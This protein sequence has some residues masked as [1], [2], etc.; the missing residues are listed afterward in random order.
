MTKEV[1]V[2]GKSSTGKTLIALALAARAREAGRR[3]SYF[4]PI[5]E[6]SYPFQEAFSVDPDA[7]L[8]KEHL[9][10]PVEPEVINPI[11]RTRASYDEFLKTGREALLSRIRECHDHV[12]K[13]YDIVIIEGA[14]APYDLLHVG[15][16]APEIARELGAE[17]ILVVAFDDFDVIDEILWSREFFE[18]HGAESVNVVL[19]IVPPMLK[20]SVE[21]EIGPLLETHGMRLMGMLV[22]HKELLAPSIRDIREVLEG[23]MILGEDRLD[24]PI[25][26]F[27]VGSMAPEN[28]LKW[29]RRAK[30]KAVIT[31]GDRADVCLAALETDTNLLILTGGI[32]P[33]VRTVA[34][35]RET[36]TAI[37]VTDKDT[38]ATSQLV[39]GLVGSIRPEDHQK[40]ATIERIVGES[41]DFSVL[42]L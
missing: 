33:D 34:R 19:T 4:K 38:F 5:G 8:M 12:S 20:H 24:V 14:K 10:L 15:L 25:T 36:S 27:M 32:G 41:V 30:D 22:Q 7:I 39:D 31:S 37:M 17:V 6:R 16:S 21:E 42:E 13:G 29:F 2:A 23:R 1:L 3:V 35:A 18:A 40:I 26:E 9:S 11:V 28:A